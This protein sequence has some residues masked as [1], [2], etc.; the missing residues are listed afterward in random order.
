[1]REDSEMKM[2]PERVI[3]SLVAQAISEIQRDLLTLGS[4]SLT[5]KVS[6]KVSLMEET[7]QDHSS[8]ARERDL[9][10]EVATSTEMLSFRG[11]EVLV[12][13]GDSEEDPKVKDPP[14][15]EVREE[16]EAITISVMGEEE[17]EGTEETS[18][19][20]KV[21]RIKLSPT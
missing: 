17:P 1:M 6:I 18:T 21:M 15:K 14:I 19:L 5:E 12:E 9:S 20:T 13:E 16:E 8:M 11:R 3:R 10:Q 7:F 2:I 4:K